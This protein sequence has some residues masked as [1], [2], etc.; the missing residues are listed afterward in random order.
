M[1]KI[2]F[3]THILP[4]IDD[5]AKRSSE[6]CEMLSLLE[7]QGVD[8]V[9][10][11]PHYYSHR[12]PIEKFLLRRNASLERLN[13][14]YASDAIH[15]CVGA[16]VYYSEY[17]FNNEDLSALCIDNTDTMLLEL[18][19]N[20]KIDRMVIDRIWQ[21]MCEYG[22]NPVIAH[23]ERYSSLWHSDRLLNDLLSMGCVL[24]VNLSSAAQFGKRRIFSLAN[25]G[26]I[27]AVGTDAHN[28]TSRPPDY[29]SGYQNMQDHLSEE[30]LDRIQSTMAMLL[31]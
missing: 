28:L 23:V 6:S 25:K 26:V 2:D 14:Q 13:A 12:E 17:L 18:P 10:L 20:K 21:L 30:V 29:H 15:F 4:A 24:Q 11:T 8:T 1:K 19:Y 7:S 22:I 27:G 31:H 5:G 9:V 3:H 16:E